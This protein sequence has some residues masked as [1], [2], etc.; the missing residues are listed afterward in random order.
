LCLWERKPRATVHPAATHPTGRGEGNSAVGEIKFDDGHGVAQMDVALTWR[1]GGPKDAQAGG[2]VCAATQCRRVAG[3]WK[4]ETYEGMEY[5]YPHANN[6]TERGA[7]AYRAMD[8]LEV[9]ITEWNAPTSK[10]SPITRATPPFPIDEL[11]AMATSP[12][13]HATASA[14]TIAAAA[15]LFTPD[16][17]PTR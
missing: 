4:V 11:V 6:S 8:G 15:G 5:P 10:D 2:D 14:R 9:D 17:E 3:G 1:T 13:W 16:P 7:R 12:T